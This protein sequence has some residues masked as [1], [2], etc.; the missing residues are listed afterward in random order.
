[1]KLDG[2]L[3]LVS[4][5]F[6]RHHPKVPKG[7]VMRPNSNTWRTTGTRERERGKTYRAAQPIIYS[8]S[9]THHYWAECV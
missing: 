7:E 9:S 8:I 5:S 6:H 3:M 4:W 1:M 2:P